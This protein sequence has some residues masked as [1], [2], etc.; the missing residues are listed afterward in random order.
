MLGTTSFFA[1]A[2]DDDDDDDFRAHFSAMEREKMKM[3]MQRFWN[4]DERPHPHDHPNTPPPKFDSQDLKRGIQLHNV[5]VHWERRCR[6]AK[7]APP[8]EWQKFLYKKWPKKLQKLHYM[9]HVG[10]LHP[11]A[12]ADYYMFGGYS[13]SDWE[14]FRATCQ[15]GMPTEVKA[16]LDSLGLAEIPVKK[17]DRK[18]Y[19][20]R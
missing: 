13:E 19:F 3:E 17:K 11:S 4:K 2:D 20:P 15:N 16:K 1:L 10:D 9:A 6:D 7:D 8:R 5:A 18:K 12:M 14:N